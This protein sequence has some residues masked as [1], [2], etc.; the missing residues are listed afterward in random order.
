[1]SVSTVN[2]ALILDHVN[3]G[4]KQQFF[5]FNYNRMKKKIIFSEEKKIDCIKTIVVTSENIL[6]QF[7][8]TSE[9]FFLK[10]K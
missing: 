10:S 4:P 2:W 5:T 7:L 6:K 1:M 3:Q 8:Y 9:A